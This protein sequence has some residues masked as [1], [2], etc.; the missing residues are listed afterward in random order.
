[1]DS[2]IYIFDSI[3]NFISLNPF[4]CLIII[5]ALVFDFTNGMHDSANSI[6]TVVS[7]RVLSP[8]YAVIWATFFNFLAIAVVG[9]EVA[10]T[11]GKGM[12]DTNMITPWVIFCWLLG[13]VCW[14]LIT[15]F[16]WLPT[17]SSHA[18]L[19]WYLWS[20]VAKAWLWAVI[21]SWWTKTI[22]FI[23]LAPMIWMI[24]WV[25]LLIW[26]TWLIYIAKK[27]I[28]LIPLG[29]IFLWI[30]FL[31][32]QESKSIWVVFW[33]MVILVFPWLYFYGNTLYSVTNLSKYM[34][35]LSSALY[36]IWHWGNDAQ[37]TMGIIVSLLLTLKASWSE[38]IP[39][40][41]II[42]P[43]GT[44]PLWVILFAYTAIAFGTITWWWKIIKTMWNSIV[45]LRPIDWF[46]ASWAWAVSLFTASHFW[47]PVSTTQ[48]IAW[49][50]TWVGLAKSFRSV[51]WGVAWHI[52][53][54][55]I[56]TIPCACWI[57]YIL[58]K[59][60]SLFF[61]F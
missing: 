14:N 37:K 61:T 27:K 49:A 46:C 52:F 39:S 43:D 41:A 3:I 51:H 25:S 59:T 31:L 58:F 7:T 53:M 20:A 2:F 33:L 5:I 29:L 35:L 30:S 40:W 55:W 26:T 38:F 4:V 21:L 47:V 34:Q 54:A 18:L 17:S 45:K 48:A 23:F 11:I 1:M 15:W 6:A 12:I 42:W 16:L 44:P 13:A 56:F 32:F 57:W 8:K 24:L 22:L 50:I 10:K 60:F 9:T 36:S 28:Y 19:W